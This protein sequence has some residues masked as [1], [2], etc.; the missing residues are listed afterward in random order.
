MMFGITVLVKGHVEVAAYVM[1]FWLLSTVQSYMKALSTLGFWP[2]QQVIPVC[3]NN[4]FL[5]E[6]IVVLPIP[7]FLGFIFSELVFV[8]SILYILCNNNT[9]ICPLY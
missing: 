9:D 8:T 6:R 4:L 5:L 1:L 3:L 7:G 2:W